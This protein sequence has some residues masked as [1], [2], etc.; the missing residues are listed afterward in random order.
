MKTLMSPAAPLAP[1][2]AF[3]L[4]EAQ[5]SLLRKRARDLEDEIRDEEALIAPLNKRD[6]KYLQ[7]MKRVFAR[8]VMVLKAHAQWSSSLSV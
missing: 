1:S 5:V 8:D 6:Q 2:Q 3:P 7:L 4:S